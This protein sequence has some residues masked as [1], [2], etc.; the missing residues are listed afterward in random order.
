MNFMRAVSSEGWGRLK[1]FRN[2]R[3]M[4]DTD[5]HMRRF[6]AAETDDVPQF[7]VDRVKRELGPFSEFLPDGFDS[8]NPNLRASLLIDQDQMIFESDNIVDYLLRT[9]PAERGQPA[10]KSAD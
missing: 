9:Y 2:L 4:L 10:R 8:M 5:L 1:Y 6:F 7:Y 3:N